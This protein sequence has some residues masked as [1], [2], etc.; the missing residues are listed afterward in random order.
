MKLSTEAKVG[1]FVVAVALAF[2]FIILTFGEIP[3][4]KRPAKH[5][6]ALF[7][8]VAG[9]SVGAEVR[10]AGVKAGKVR[11]VRVKE[12]RVEV[13]FEVDKDI[14]IYRDAYV[15]IGTLGLMGDKY[16]SVIPGSPQAGLLPEGGRVERVGG[17]ADTD[18]LV[19]EMTNAAQ[20]LRITVESLQMVMTEN[21]EN[22][23]S[24]IR[25]IEELSRNLNLMVLENRANLKASIENL[26]LLLASLNRTLPK[27]IASIEK[28]AN[29]LDSMAVENREDIRAMV[30]NLRQISSDLRTT[31]PELTQNLNDMSKNLNTM[32]TDNR[33]NIKQTVSNFSELSKSLKE[34]SDRLNLILAR[35]ERGEG[36]LGKL[37]TD[38]EL[39]KNVTQ[40]TKT[41]SKTTDVAERTNLYI[42]F[43]GEFF[44]EGDSKGIL[45]VKLQPDNEKY[46]LL[47]VVG[48]SR[49]RYTKEEYNGNV[50][51]KKEFKPEITIQYA[52]M[53]PVFGDKKLVVRGGLKESTGGFGAD[54][55]YND[56]LTFTSDV[57]DFGRRDYKNVRKD[58]KANVQVAAEYKLRG[59]LYVKVGGDDLLNPKLRGPFIG[60]GLLFTDNDLKY[61]MGG[62]R[63]P[64]P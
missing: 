15:E 14:P 5:Y 18:L 22:I 29:D 23:S 63:L 49:G 55:I 43:R 38:E 42:G 48:D 36:T 2:A 19:K 62:M 25:N 3:F 21:R 1:G 37:V 58:L 26:N 53:F 16:L 12:G 8:N 59:P 6:S 10:V 9:L 64:L 52:R 40:F 30:V 31:L 20:S 17:Y 4:L 44:K 45:T 50:L 47:E 7:D 54:L 11:Q 35:I 46:Y 28:L 57:W 24:A 34:S 61:L 39:Y 32:L 56:R 41:L 51:I 13:I 27:T 33:E 60:V